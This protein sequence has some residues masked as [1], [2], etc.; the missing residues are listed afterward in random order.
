[1]LLLRNQRDRVSVS[2]AKLAAGDYRRPLNGGYLGLRP[3]PRRL[4]SE[5]TD[6]YILSWLGWIAY[7]V[8]KQRP[9]F[10]NHSKAPTL[11]L[12]LRSTIDS[13]EEAAI[14]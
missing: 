7:G 5:K 4:G 12:I 10:V 13:T 2:S 1:M 3:I 6:P 9:V 11:K 14:R 8:M